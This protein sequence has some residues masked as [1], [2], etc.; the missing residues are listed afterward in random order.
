M[1][2]TFERAKPKEGVVYKGKAWNADAKGKNTTSNY[3]PLIIG[4]EY[5]WLGPTFSIPLDWQVVAEPLG[6]GFKLIWHNVY[7]N[8]NEAMALCIRTFFGYDK[9]KRDEI[10]RLVNQASKTRASVVTPETASTVSVTASQCEACGATGARLY[11]YHT[12]MSYFF[13]YSCKM[14][15]HV[16]CTNHGRSK[17]LRYFIGNILLGSWG[18]SGLFGLDNLANCKMAYRN[19][20]IS[21]GQA[22]I[23]SVLTFMPLFLLLSLIAF[24]IYSAIK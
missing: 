6:P 1:V 4:P 12:V 11:D 7:E 9:E 8:K 2:A 15:R 19:G 22:T 21:K 14:R 18:F 13:S 23:Y 24:S 20:A 16:L 17:M 5:I 3:F 10:V